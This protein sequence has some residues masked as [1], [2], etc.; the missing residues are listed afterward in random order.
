[1][2]ERRLSGLVGSDIGS[3]DAKSVY[4]ALLDQ[5]DN[6]NGSLKTLLEQLH[7]RHESRRITR[8]SKKLL[9]KC[10]ATRKHASNLYNAVIRGKYWKCPCKDS[11]CVHLRIE[12]E[13]VE[14]VDDHDSS[15]KMPK[16]R[17]AFST[18]IIDPVRP[19]SWHWEEVETVP[20]LLEMP[21]VAQNA[22]STATYAAGP[23][24]AKYRRVQFAV[25]TPAS[26]S[27]SLPEVPYIPPNLP[28][29]DF[30]S[31]LCKTNQ[32]DSLKKY[33]GSISDD[34]HTKHRYCLLLMEK[35]DETVETQSLEDLLSSSLIPIGSQATRPAFFFS[36]RDRLFL[37]ATLASSVLQFHGSWLKSYWRSRD[38][39]FPKIKDTNESVVD[40]PYLAGHGLSNSTTEPAARTVIKPLIPSEIL[41]PLGLVLVEL[42]LSRSIWALRIAEDADSVEAYANLKTATRVLDQVVRE[43]GANYCDVVNKCFHWSETRNST[44]DDEDFQKLVL[45]QIVGP[46]VEDFK[47]FEGKG[48]IH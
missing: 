19:I 46:L 34:C 6:A 4:N 8:V 41:F 36:R 35:H 26:P 12:S 1:M 38:I 20:E 3:P 44:A 24:A 48:R 42:S 29:P 40:R 32:T 2:V 5:V 14:L 37:A 16:F 28:I 11:H 13:A 21:V 17:M 15:S 30:C 22:V 43:S 39:L 27:V 33:L 9:L 7:H 18:R 10:R 25:V 23:R 47:D 31:V 45:Q